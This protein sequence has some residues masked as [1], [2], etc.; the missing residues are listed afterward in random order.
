MACTGTYA[1]PDAYASFWCSAGVLTGYDDSGGAGNAS[2]SDSGAEFLNFNVAVD[3]VVYNQTESTSGP[4]TA[5]T[6]TTITATGVT[7]SDGDQW[8][9]V[10]LTIHERATI[11]TFL[12]TTANDIHAVVDSV[13]ACDCSLAAW[14][15]AF[16]G[17]LN[18]VEA[19]AFH[20]CPCAR[21]ALTETD[22]ANLLAWSD[23]QLDLIRMGKIELCDGHTG[24]DYPSVGWAPRSLTAWTAAE[25]IANDIQVESG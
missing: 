3:M 10:P 1:T 5:V 20:R 19:G 11:E 7:W 4:I 18:I 2:L 23:R 13:G 6:Q 15:E 25:I 24:S 9:L 16:L 21:P 17:K 14:A 22:R 8:W 12:D